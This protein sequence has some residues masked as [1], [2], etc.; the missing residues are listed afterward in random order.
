MSYT[1]KGKKI[2]LHGMFQ[3]ANVID[4]PIMKGGHSG[5]QVAYPTAVI[6][7]ENGDIEHVH[8]YQ[9]KRSDE[10]TKQIKQIYYSD[11]E[12]AIKGMAALGWDVVSKSSWEDSYNSPTM[13]E[14]I[15]ERKIG[16][17]KND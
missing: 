14:V 10:K 16:A 4:P 11:P 17:I 13:T 5:G 2:K 7:H 3:Y 12:K 6:E 9:I 15:Y 1:Y 8:P